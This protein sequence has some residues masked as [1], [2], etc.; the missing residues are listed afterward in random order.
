MTDLLATTINP[1][2][3]DAL[4]ARARASPRRRLNLNLHAQLSDPIQRFLNA[5]EPGSYVRPHR[6]RPERW[7]LF[8]VLRGQ[9]DLLLFA[10]DGTLLQHTALQGGSG[11][12]VEVA[13]GSWHSFIIT[14]PGTVGLEVK[15]GPY[16]AE[17][18]KEFASW[19]PQEGT[20]E[21]ERLL[22]WLST[23]RPGERWPLGF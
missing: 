17:T 11:S 16:V 8:T 18:D 2:D 19:A 23:A 21:A 7:E 14:A 6:H 22:A 12:I 15:P 20:P 9:M 13:G 10:D 5:G 4:I 3:I 1:A